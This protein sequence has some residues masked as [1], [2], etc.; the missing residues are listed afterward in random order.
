MTV[1]WDVHFDIPG[2]VLF[3]L[4]VAGTWWLRSWEPAT[5]LAALGFICLGF[6]S[7]ICLCVGLGLFLTPR[8]STGG[9]GCD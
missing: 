3:L 1:C 9:R 8:E 7:V 2:A 6:L 5:Q 4:G